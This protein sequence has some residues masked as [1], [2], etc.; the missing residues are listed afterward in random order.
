MKL[1]HHRDQKDAKVRLCRPF[2]LCGE[3]RLGTGSLFYQSSKVSSKLGI[4]PSN[5]LHM[6][7]FPIESDHEIETEAFMGQEIERKFLV[8]GETWRTNHGTLIRQGYL[9]N[10]VDGTVRVRTKGERAYLTI[11]GGTIGITRLEFEYEIPLEEADQILDELCQKPL[12]EKTRYEV[13]VSG[14]KW[15]IDEFLGE[16]AGLVVAEIELEDENQEFIKPDWL[17]E[18][19][20]GDFRYQNANLVKHPYSQ[21]DE[22]S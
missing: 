16:N 20:S 2:G 7:H 10:E 11:K 18:E 4:G 17:G 19:V 12:I 3:K 9:H 21:W 15:E 1:G 5:L 8:T 13:D 6:K 14:S 22:K